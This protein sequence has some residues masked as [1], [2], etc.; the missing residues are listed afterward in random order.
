MQQVLQE[1][2]VQEAARLALLLELLAHN[3][4]NAFVAEF[5]VEALAGTIGLRQHRTKS[6]PALSVHQESP[7]VCPKFGRFGL[8]N[9]E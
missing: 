1:L 3:L 6:W 4:Q 8:L 7:E 9:L 2:A 5:G